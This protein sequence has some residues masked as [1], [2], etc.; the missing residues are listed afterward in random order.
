MK[1]HFLG[2]GGFIGKGLPYNS[3][4]IDDNFLIECP[5]D[6][7]TT[8][9][10]QG[11]QLSQIKKIY[12][13]HFH[14]DH[15]FGMP[16]L[17]LNLLARYPEKTPGAG[18]IDVIGPKGI[19]E[20]L[21]QLQQIAVSPDNPSVSGIDD[22]YNFQEIDQSSYLRLNDKHEMLFHR[23]SHPKETY[24]FS[25]VSDNKHQLAYLADTVWDDSFLKIISNKPKYVI[26]DLNS[27]S[28]DKKAMHMSE[29][30]IIENAIPVTGDATIYVGT[31]LK[32]NRIAT[33]KNLIY[34]TPGTMLEIANA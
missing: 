6:I 20:H 11:I 27:D 8:M 10:N 28:A 30:D 34:A 16:F 19:R 13:S 15:Y 14:G 26:C 24:G 9:R 23:M 18:K 1:I 22:I 4:L 2:N 17:T 29:R 32:D 12:I 7:M 33:Q 21:I 3:F 31:H 5:P 25:I